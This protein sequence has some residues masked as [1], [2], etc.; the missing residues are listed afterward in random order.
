MYKEHAMKDIIDIAGKS[1]WTEDDIILAFHVLKHR[2]K[3]RPEDREVMKY[4]NII[5]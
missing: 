3:I 5:K 2:M 1:K 4:M